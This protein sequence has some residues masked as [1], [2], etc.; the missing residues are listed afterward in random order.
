MMK[1]QGPNPRL[2]HSQELPG[3][4]VERKWIIEVQS[5]YSQDHYYENLRTLERLLSTGYCLLLSS[6]C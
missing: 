4:L 5:H 1:L 3:S 2:W 6:I